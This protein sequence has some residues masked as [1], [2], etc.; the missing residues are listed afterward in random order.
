MCDLCRE[1]LKVNMGALTRKDNKFVFRN[2]R[3]YWDKLQATKTTVPQK[4]VRIS[5]SVDKTTLRAVNTFVTNTLL[6][7]QENNKAYYAIGLHYY[8]RSLLFN[9][10]T[11]K[12]NN[13]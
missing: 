4:L 9:F 2:W 6:V 7:T 3:T 13:N 1:L 8:N 5:E 12:L 10:V 11:I